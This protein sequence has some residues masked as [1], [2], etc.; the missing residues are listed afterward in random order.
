MKKSIALSLAFLIMIS[1]HRYVQGERFGLVNRPAF[2]ITPEVLS[3]LRRFG[4]NEEMESAA[5]AF[6]E[7]KDGV[8]RISYANVTSDYGIV[9]LEKY[10]GN[11]DDESDWIAGISQEHVANIIS[12][13]DKALESKAVAGWVILRYRSGGREF[14]GYYKGG[15]YLLTDSI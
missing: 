8:Y 3:E 12:L 5:R 6:I 11:L 15:K 9:H 2:T 7:N 1:C 13:M 14:I 10:M 4:I